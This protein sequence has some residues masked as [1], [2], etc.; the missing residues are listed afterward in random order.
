LVEFNKLIYQSMQ[1]EFNEF[2]QTNGT[3]MAYKTKPGY[4]KHIKALIESG[5]HCKWLQFIDG[6]KL[7]DGKCPKCGGEVGARRWAV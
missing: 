2:L 1:K 5:K 4:C 7:K 6:G 3:C